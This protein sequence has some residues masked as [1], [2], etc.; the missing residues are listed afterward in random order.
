MAEELIVLK[1]VFEWMIKQNVS[2]LVG[3]FDYG[4]KKYK[5]TVKEV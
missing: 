1:F 2:N 3:D 4:N 5:V